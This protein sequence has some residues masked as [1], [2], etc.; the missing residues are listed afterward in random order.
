MLLVFAS[1]AVDVVEPTK[2][3]ES[4]SSSSEALANSIHCRGF[5][6]QKS[7]KLN[8]YQQHVVIGCCP[9]GCWSEN[10]FIFT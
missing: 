2:E 5:S 3:Y 8:Q 9:Y 4:L 7:F 1:D 10:S 6:Q